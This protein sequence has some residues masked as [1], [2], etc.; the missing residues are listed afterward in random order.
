MEAHPVFRI[1]QLQL[2][3]HCCLNL[4]ETLE[5]MRI[6]YSFVTTELLVVK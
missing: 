4:R 3:D 2:A 6:R 5:E 1:R